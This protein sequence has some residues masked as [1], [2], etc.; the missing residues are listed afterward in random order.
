MSDGGASADAGASVAAPALSLFDV[1]EAPDM[2]HGGAPARQAIA[3]PVARRA[4]AGRRRPTLLAVDGNSLVHRAFHAYGAP[5]RDSALGARGGLYGFLALLAAICDRVGPAGLIVGFDCRVASARKARYPAYKAGRGDKHADL[6]ELLDEAPTILLELGVAVVV[7]RGWEADDVCGSAAATAEANGWHCVVATSDRDAYA[8]VS[9]ATTVLRLRS[10]MDNA[11]EVTPQRLRSEFGID[12]ARYLEFAALRGDTSD[13]LPGIPGIGPSRAAALLR[14]YPT[15]ADAVA[16]PLGCRS[17]LGRP[18]GQALIDDLSDAASSV[19]LRNVALMRIRRDLP[20]ELP[21]T[22]LRVAPGV[23]RDRLAAWGVLGLDARL[24]TALCDRPAVVPL[25]D[26][27]PP[28][29]DGDVGSGP[30]P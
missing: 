21:A 20:V 23:V 28:P 27:A 25:G 1:A 5:D 2:A 4:A 29:A 8:L 19:F 26:L 12:G 16:D 9:D 13:N 15:V 10:G 22:R 17:V 6:D 11:V 14:A 18:L 30:R 7:A 24:S 3:A